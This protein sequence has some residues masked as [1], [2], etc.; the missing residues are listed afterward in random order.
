[1]KQ[2]RVA[3]TMLEV[4]RVAGHIGAEL[5]GVDIGEDLD[6]LT[7]YEIRQA[8][9]EHKVVFLRN[10]S[11]T[12]Q[13]HID[14]AR[15]LGPLTRRSEPH[16]G[17]HP[18][19]FPEIYSMDPTL[20]DQ[21]FGVGFQSRYRERWN[22]YYVGWHTDL[23]PAVN[24]PAISILR[25]ERCPSYGG[26]TQWTNLVAAYNG[27]SEP[28]RH[29]VDG[30]HAE[31]AFF[32]GCQI[33][34]HDKMDQA[35]LRLHNDYPLVSV[36]PVVR[37][38]PETG[39]KALFVNPSLTARIVGLSPVESRHLLALLFEQITRPEYTCRFR[40]EVDSV[41]MWDNRATAHLAATD[42]GETVE[43]RTMH[44]VTVLG[45]R[46]VGPDGFESTIVAGEAF[47]PLEPGAAGR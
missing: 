45:D 3:P 39:E 40:W 9:L 23:S 16:R 30:L 11:L 8:I 33:R 21:R 44:R 27:L 12:H 20:E 35:I 6:E 43:R 19:G 15:R 22:H 38:H 32:A 25:A 7:L 47:L 28:L 13:K 5:V 17:L 36:H 46:P 14:F 1:M 2:A 18:E 41:A 34:Q 24:P 31:H 4:R 42:F 37:V 10:Q 26:D 29:F